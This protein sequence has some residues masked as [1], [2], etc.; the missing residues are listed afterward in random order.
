MAG[1]GVSLFCVNLCCG[2]YP[3][4]VPNIGDAGQEQ[5]YIECS[6]CKKK[7]YVYGGALD[8]L[9]EWQHYSTVFGVESNKDWC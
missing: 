5:V 9:I 7:T 6:I 8:A 2:E 3:M 1:K 4:L